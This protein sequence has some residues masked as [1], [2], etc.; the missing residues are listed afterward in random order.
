M[1]PHVTEIQKTYYFHSLLLGSA[2][3]TFCNIE[4]S[5]KESLDEIMTIFKRCFGNYLSMEKAR[6]ERDALKFELSSQKLQNFLDIFQKTAKEALGV[7][8]P[9]LR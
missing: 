4:D 6:C 8:A 7:E 1:H 2:L 9:E 3:Q 5:K